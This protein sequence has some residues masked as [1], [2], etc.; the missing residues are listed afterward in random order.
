MKAKRRPRFQ[1]PKKE[2]P[3]TPSGKAFSSAFTAPDLPDPA[4]PSPIASIIDEKRFHLS[5]TQTLA[6]LQ[7]RELDHE[8]AG[9]DGG[10]APLDELARRAH[11]PAGGEQIVDERDPVPFSDGVLVHLQGVGPVFQR[12]ALA[13]LGMRKLVRLSQRDQPE[14][15]L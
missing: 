4:C 9:D 11:R 1:L 3:R 7:R 15:E 10:A 14:S 5:S 8:E 12:V 2:A 6:P 13:H